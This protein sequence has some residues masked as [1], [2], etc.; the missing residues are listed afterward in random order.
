MRIL[1]IA[2]VVCAVLAG[3]S[4]KPAT[5][6][7]PQGKIYKLEDVDKELRDDGVKLDASRETAQTFFKNHPDY[8]VCVDNEA[9]L[10]AVWRNTKVDPKST[11]QYIVIAYRDSKIANLDIGPAMLSVGNVAGYCK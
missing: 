1:V 10:I 8:Q 7:T 9:S 3:C 5:P 11:D 2:V 6:T 4:S